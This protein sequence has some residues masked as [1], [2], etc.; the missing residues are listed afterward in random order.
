MRVTYNKRRK[1]FSFW[2]GKELLFKKCR[3]GKDFKHYTTYSILHPNGGYSYYEISIY[4]LVVVIKEDKTSS[5]YFGE[6]Q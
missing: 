3:P 2:E 1:M 5:Y 6:A 4:D